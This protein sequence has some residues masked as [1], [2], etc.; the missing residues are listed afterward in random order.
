MSAKCINMNTLKL[1][2]FVITR[3]FWRVLIDQIKKDLWFAYLYSSLHR[4]CYSEHQ[5]L[6]PPPCHYLQANR[7]T[8]NGWISCGN[9]YCWDT[10]DICKRCESENKKYYYVKIANTHFWWNF[11]KSKK[12]SGGGSKVKKKRKK[13]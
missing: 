8:V 4:I 10:S 2:R 6:S 13:K 3:N 11:I 5:I 9:W 1:F 7:E 12:E